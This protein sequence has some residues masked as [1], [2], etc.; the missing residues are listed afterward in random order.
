MTLEKMRPLSFLPLRRNLSTAISAFTIGLV[1]LALFTSGVFLLATGYGIA[2][3][4]ALPSTAIFSLADWSTVLVDA[5]PRIPAGLIVTALS[6]ACICW[7][8]KLGVLDPVVVAKMEQSVGS[9]LRRG[10]L[11]AV[12]A[13]L[14]LIASSGG[15]SGRYTAHPSASWGLFNIVPWS[16]SIVYF[17]SSLDRATLN[18]WGD[19]AARRPMAQALRDATLFLTG[20]FE[21]TAILLQTVGVALALAIAAGRIV[22]WRGTWA[23]I[24]FVAFAALAL[25]PYL[26]SMMTEPIALGFTF[27]ACAYLFDAVRYR[28]P[29]HALVA[30]TA[31]AAALVMRAGSLFTLPALLL[32]MAVAFGPD[33]RTRLRWALLG[34][35]CIIAV[36]GLGVALQVA[37]A[38]ASAAGAAS[39]ALPLCGI[40]VGGSWGDCFRLYAKEITDL[41]QNDR[42]IMLLLLQKAMQ[43]IVTDPGIALTSIARNVTKYLADFPGVYFSGPHKALF[44]AAVALGLVATWWKHRGEAAF[45]IVFFASTAASAAIIYADDG[46]RAMLVSYAILAAPIAFAFASPSWQPQGNAPPSALRGGILFASFAL[47]ALIAPAASH[48]AMQRWL[49]NYDRPSDVRPDEALL[50]GAPAVTGFLV[51]PDNTPRPFDA[52][53]VS[54]TEFLKIA[55]V[56]AFKRDYG[57]DVHDMQLKPPFAFMV[58]MRLNPSCCYYISSPDV[59]TAHHVAIWRLSPSR[60]LPWNAIREMRASPVAL[61][62]TRAQHLERQ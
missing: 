13:L 25:R 23:G 27:L 22:A 56:N 2:T 60:A 43:N 44:M 40:S 59:L 62:G 38:P 9:L 45:W 42:A 51:I 47:V 36:F 48:A 16:D 24:A 7:L 57:F 12:I 30:V 5:E 11:F 49:A 37:Y 29:P 18:S 3:G 31:I 10:G 1:L 34:T 52:P 21:P 54:Y 17:G 8:A 35:V 6:G 28:S 32:C 33:M 39:I 26:G 53:A 41:Q 50:V 61:H 58:G 15:W 14:L 20:Y 19:V 46:L 4:Y 55:E